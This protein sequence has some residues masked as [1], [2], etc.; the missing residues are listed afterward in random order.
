MLDAS[1]LVFE[2]ALT[3]VMQIITS[4]LSSQQYS[5]TRPGNPSSYLNLET[6]Y[7]LSRTTKRQPIQGETQK[8]ATGLRG[9]LSMEVSKLSEGKEEEK[10]KV[11]T[12]VTRLK[13]NC[14]IYLIL[15]WPY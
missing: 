15:G 7:F 11:L 4:E 6:F 12:R 3:K 9:G 10:N 5:R 1:A 8:Q 2:Y 14:D 13:E